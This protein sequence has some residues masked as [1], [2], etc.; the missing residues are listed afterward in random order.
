MGLF[1]YLDIIGAVYP[2]NVWLRN[3]K[4]VH[5]PKNGL[6]GSIKGGLKA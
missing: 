6:Q 3:C 2:G 4:I 1:M 5:Y